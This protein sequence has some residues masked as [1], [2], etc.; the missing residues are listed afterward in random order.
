MI[1][2]IRQAKPHREIETLLFPCT[3]SPPLCS[4]LLGIL[5][6]LSP[7]GDEPFLSYVSYA[8]GQRGRPLPYSS[9]TREPCVLW[10]ILHGCLNMIIYEARAFTPHSPRPTASLLL[11]S[12]TYGH[13]RISTLKLL[14]SLNLV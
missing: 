3:G 2:R 12:R 4:L 8:S 6:F 7:P 1:L 9:K 13:M 10:Q 14:R 5:M 11:F